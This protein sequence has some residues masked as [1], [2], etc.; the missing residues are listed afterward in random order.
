MQLSECQG[1]FLQPG[2]IM[3]IFQAP[4]VSLDPGAYLYAPAGIG[5]DQLWADPGLGHRLQYLTLGLAVEP[6]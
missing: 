1:Q 6:Q 5:P 3:G 4:A 2:R